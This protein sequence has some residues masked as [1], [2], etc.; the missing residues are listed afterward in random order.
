MQGDLGWSCMLSISLP[1][2]S[3]RIPLMTH[4]IL[5]SVE[6]KRANGLLRDSSTC[7]GFPKVFASSSMKNKW[8]VSDW[9]AKS[10]SP[11]IQVISVFC[12]AVAP[13]GVAEPFSR[14]IN[15][16][17]SPN[18]IWSL[19]SNVTQSVLFCSVFCLLSLFHSKIR[20]N[21]LLLKNL[22]GAAGSC[23]VKLVGI[24]GKLRPPC[25]CFG[26]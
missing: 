19:F 26:R 17:H 12:Y 4:L 23:S 13:L 3:P 2:S 25:D 18:V 5:I 1:I 7:W 16:L 21:V 22:L 9:E 6:V 8:M 20:L 11:N 15:S 24:F 14:W 10:A